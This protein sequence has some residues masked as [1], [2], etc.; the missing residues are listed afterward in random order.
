MTRCRTLLFLIAFSA[1]LILPIFQFSGVAS[2][3]GTYLSMA[4]GVIAGEGF[5]DTEGQP[6]TFRPPTYPI[7]LAGMLTLSGG[8]LIGVQIIQALLAALIAPLIYELLAGR[9]GRGRAFFGGLIFALD[10]VSIPVPAYILT[11]AIGSVLLILWLA[12]WSR[13]YRK[14]SFGSYV[15][16][17][18]LG[19]ALVYQSM[20]TLLLH[21]IALLLRAWKSTRL[22]LLSAIIFALP[23]AAWTARNHIVL[24]EATS[25]RSAGFGFL[26]WATMNY[27]FPWL[28]SP[29]DPRGTYIIRQEHRVAQGDHEIFLK[30]AIVRFRAEPLRCFKRVVKASFWAWAEVPGAMKS[31]DRFPAVRWALVLTNACILLLALFGIRGAVKTA[32]GRIALGVILYFGI[33]LAPLFPIPRYFLPIR[34]MLAILAGFAAHRKSFFS[35]RC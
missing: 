25:V 8:C 20:I 23:M 17:G 4:K 12:A 27:D 26:I 21:P 22:V 15:F 18:L 6:T 16:A 31:L 24:G 35:C 1:R 29:Y 5:V 11:E 28:L 19:G 9:I 30:K 32:E 2:D 33:F 10:P 3:S 7:F 34:P 14:A 13:I